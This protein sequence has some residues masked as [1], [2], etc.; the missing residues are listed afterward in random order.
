MYTHT[1]TDIYKHK[2]TET[3]THIIYFNLLWLICEIR[4]FSPKK[5]PGK[6]QELLSLTIERNAANFESFSLPEDGEV[7]SCL[8]ISSFR[9]V[10]DG[11]SIKN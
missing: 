11:I 5:I 8:S 4:F 2:D 9:E 1:H 7:P 6:R 10:E 3:H